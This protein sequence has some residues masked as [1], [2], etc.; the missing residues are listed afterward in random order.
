MLLPTASGARSSVRPAGRGLQS[1]G[2][3]TPRHR[4]LPMNV[5]WRGVFP[6][7]TTEFNTDQS[8]NLAATVGHAEAMVKAGVHGMIVLGTV[9]ENCS[10]EYPEKLGVLRRAVEQA[11]GRV[12]VL[13]GVA[14]CST[15]LA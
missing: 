13:A 10:L 3:A 6:A 9:G 15:A 5:T 4:S 8:V 2:S 1:A 7:A 11:A 12:P 14:E